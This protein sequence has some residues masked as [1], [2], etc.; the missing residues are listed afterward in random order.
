MLF[1][2][3]YAE[4][5]DNYTISFLYTKLPMLFCM[6]YKN[7]ISSVAYNRKIESQRY[8]HSNPNKSKLVAKYPGRDNL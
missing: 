1:I 3:N 8:K 5:G 2:L 4:T 6:V 7:N